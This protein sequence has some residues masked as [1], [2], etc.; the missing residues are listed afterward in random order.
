MGNSRVKIDRELDFSET[1]RLEM[2]IMC[3]N[4]MTCRLVEGTMGVADAPYV[5]QLQRNFNAI[6]AQFLRES[7]TDHI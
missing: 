7:H 4:I 1:F 3:Q 6:R 5:L 2:W